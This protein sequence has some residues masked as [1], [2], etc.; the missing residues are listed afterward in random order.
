ME[1]GIDIRNEW[2]NLSNNG[3]V[4]SDE[5]CEIHSAIIT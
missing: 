5:I 2:T 3:Y 4:E 1:I